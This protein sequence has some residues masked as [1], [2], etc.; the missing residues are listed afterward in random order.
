MISDTASNWTHNLFC[1]R[2]APIPLGYCDGRLPRYVNLTTYFRGWNGIR[3]T[4]DFVRHCGLVGSA[5]AWDGTGC[6]FD[7]WQ[8]R[9]YFPCSLSL[10]L[11]GFLRGSLGTYGLTQK[12][13]LKKTDKLYRG[14]MLVSYMVESFQNSIMQLQQK[15]RFYWLEKSWVHGKSNTN[16]FVWPLYNALLSFHLFIHIPAYQ[17]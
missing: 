13:C 4:N 1:P 8:C 11:L 7:S 5:S 12:L 10:R 2:C 3:H 9:I 6:E 15:I 14:W 16:K 17:I